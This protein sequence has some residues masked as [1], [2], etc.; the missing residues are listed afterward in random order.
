MPR[1]APGARKPRLI[2]ALLRE[3]ATMSLAAPAAGQQRVDRERKIV[4]GVKLGGFSSPNK[5]DVEGVT[6]TDYERAAV[7]RALP[8]YE[9]RQA[10]SDHPDRKNP[11]EERPARAALGIYHNARIGDD[12]WYAD[13]HLVPSHELTEN[14]LDVAERDDLAGVYSLSHNAHGEGEVRGNRYVITAITEVRSVDV[15][16]RGATTKTLFESQEPTVK[17]KLKEAVMAGKLPAKVKAAVLEMAVCEEDYEDA[18]DSPDA[19][20]DHLVSAVGNLVKSDDEEAHKRAKSILKML[21]P[22]S[23]PALEESDDE[24]A[25]E[26]EPEDKDKKAVAMAESRELFT[27]AGV[28]A[29]ARLLESVASIPKLADRIAFVNELKGMAPA[30][31]PGNKPP[32]GGVRGGPTLESVGPT[33]DQLRTMPLS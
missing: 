4:Y 25:D 9:G 2:S 3:S 7:Q 16:T 14:I 24:P 5:H 15:V 19:W 33:Y 11:R 31:K 32:P 1:T 6:G 10:F 21:E 27:L 30:T 28:K 23:A 17:K 13:L 18:G 20:K 8:L 22:E 12:G 26:D 29:S